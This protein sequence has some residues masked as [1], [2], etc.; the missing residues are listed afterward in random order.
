M[1]RPEIRLGISAAA[2][3]AGIATALTAAKP[4]IEII[5]LLLAIVVSSA[6][7]AYWRHSLRRAKLEECRLMAPFCGHE[8]CRLAECPF[9]KGQR[10]SHCSVEKW[11]TA[12]P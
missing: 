3:W 6:A 5:A 12:K 4:V 2:S 10:P 11:E 9:P 7:L 8:Q 1:E